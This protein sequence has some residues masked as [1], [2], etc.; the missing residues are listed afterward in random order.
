MCMQ[1]ERCG[2]RRQN[3][4]TARNPIVIYSSA[5]QAHEAYKEEQINHI[6]IPEV[7]INMLL[8]ENFQFCYLVPLVHVTSVTFLI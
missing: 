6:G 7:Y 1:T 8:W 3:M 5:I 2:K 4:I